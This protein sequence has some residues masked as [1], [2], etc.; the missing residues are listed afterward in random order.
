[1]STG[2]CQAI[3]LPAHLSA[4][5]IILDTAQ[6]CSS[7]QIYNLQYSP[8]LNPDRKAMV[9]SRSSGVETWHRRLTA[10]LNGQMGRQ[11]LNA[12]CEK[13]NHSPQVGT[14]FTNGLKPASPVW[15]H[16]G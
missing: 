10:A 15:R 4:D 9:R 8:H 12:P 7:M 13:T 16:G 2:H 11:R 14:P 5:K 1:M 6:A 3:N